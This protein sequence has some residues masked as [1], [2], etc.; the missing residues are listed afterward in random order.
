[1]Q[2]IFFSSVFK[3]IKPLFP[4]ILNIKGWQ[5]FWNYLQKISFSYAVLTLYLSKFPAEMKHVI[6]SWLMLAKEY[7][8]LMELSGFDQPGM[9]LNNLVLSLVINNWIALCGLEKPCMAL[10]DLRDLERLAWPW[11]I[12]YDLEQSYMVLSLNR[13]VGLFWIALYDLDYWLIL[14]GLE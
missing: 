7:F 13:L 9:V 1:M 12:F 4:Y 14:R 5:Q 8:K 6:K 3:R 10:K 2:S 11:M